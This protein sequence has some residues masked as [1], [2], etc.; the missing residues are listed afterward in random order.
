VSRILRSVSH[1]LRS[2]SDILRSANDILRSASDILRDVAEKLPRCALRGHISRVRPTSTLVLLAVP[3]L[4]AISVPAHAASPQEDELAYRKAAESFYALKADPAKRRARE[5][6]VRAAARFEAVAQRYP[7]SPRAPQAL[8]SAADLYNELS[9]ISFV[10]GDRRKT[11]SV[12]LKL[13]KT[14][15][16]DRLAD[17]ALYQAARIELDRDDDPDAA[18]AHLDQLLKSYPHGDMVRRARA[19]MAQVKAASKEE[20]RTPTVRSHPVPPTEAGEEEANDDAPTPVTTT[21]TGA[22]RSNPSSSTPHPGPP[23]QAGEEDA[24]REPATTTVAAPAAP[25]A[26]RKA[27]TTGQPAVPSHIGPSPLEALRRVGSAPGGVPLAVQMGLRVHRVIVDP[28]HGGHDN[29]AVGP[30]G[31]KEKD[32]TLAIARRLAEDLRQQ[33]LEVILTREDDRYVSL[34]ERAAIANRNHADLFISVHCNAARDHRLHGTETYSLN[35]TSDRYAIRLAARE[36]QASER[37]VSDLSLILAD[38]ATKADVVESESLAES[39]QRTL[40]E[41]GERNLGV[42]HALFYVLLGA[43]MPAV[44]VES[45]FLSNPEEERELKNP[46]HQLEIAQ[47]IS[48]GVM[49]FLDQRTGFAAV[50]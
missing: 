40:V 27:E 19:L 46:A 43:K 24:D 28:G 34:E 25:P 15:P 36:N 5:L 42:K 32:V 20:V 8:Y 14:Y 37:S 31:T 23:P 16:D 9:R 4:L 21:T 44:L 3:S 11:L 41:R 38:L 1:I 26:T 10:K 45:A 39:V 17:D 29:G 35:V 7:S 33:G 6:W 13:A 12:Y 22:A 18:R 49:R 2:V 47:R 48:Q 50:P 30:E